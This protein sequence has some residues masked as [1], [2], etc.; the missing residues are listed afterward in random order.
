MTAGV[1]TG[2]YLQPPLLLSACSAQPGRDGCEGQ[3][4]PTPGCC[5][6]WMWM[7]KQEPV[8]LLLFLMTSLFTSSCVCAAEAPQAESRAAL[9]R[10]ALCLGGFPCCGARRAQVHSQGA[11]DTSGDTSGLVTAQWLHCAPTKPVH[12]GR[13]RGRGTSWAFKQVSGSFT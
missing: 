3:H 4:L 10:A 13:G 12:L 11:G 6:F 8:Y 5:S 7:C 2:R 1:R 9:T